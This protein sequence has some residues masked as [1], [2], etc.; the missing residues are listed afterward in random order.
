MA[1]R[2]ACSGL[3]IQE[4]K[5]TNEPC[6]CWGRA[7]RSEVARRVVWAAG[8][9]QNGDLALEE[10]EAHDTWPYQAGKSRSEI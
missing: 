6:P 3:E 7:L 1:L 10:K 8:L 2:A 9:T 5:Q 4:N